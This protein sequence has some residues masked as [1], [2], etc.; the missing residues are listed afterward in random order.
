M[1]KRRPR[2]ADSSAQSDAA[3]ELRIIGGRLRGRRLLYDGSPRTRPMKDRVREATFNLVGP[4]VKGT[5]AID[6]FAGTGAI[7]LEA[8][9]RGA[10]GA[11]LI[12]R[13][14]PT[15]KG[16]SAN[17]DRL[18]LG[19]LVDVLAAN[20]FH[21]ARRDLA[22][23]PVDAPWSIFCSPPYDFYVERLE[24]MLQLIQTLWDAAPPGSLLVVESDDR[25]DFQELPDAERWNIRSYPPAQVGVLRNA[26]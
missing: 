15:A 20:T 2:K 8:V 25:F 5:Y 16:I 3:A 13:H 21:W 9:S 22:Q 10:A 19:G 18:E 26:V 17:V 4:G 12:E 24:E 1:P 23:L 11:T 14:V 6:L 7:G